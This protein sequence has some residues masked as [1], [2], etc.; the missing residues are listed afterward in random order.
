MVAGRTSPIASVSHQEGE[1]LSRYSSTLP[2]HHVYPVRVIP[3]RPDV[4]AVGVPPVYQH[5]GDA[6]CDL[7]AA[8]T[9]EIPPGGQV[10]VPTGLRLALPPGY[11]GLVL[12]RSGL[13][14]RHGVTLVNSPGLIDAGY[15]GEISV[16]MWNTRSDQSFTV[17]AGDRIAQLVIA[18][19]SQGLFHEVGSLPGSDRGMGGFGST[20][21]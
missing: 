17:T 14:L 6:G 18:P 2:S 7:L 1:S 11:M 3:D 21:V 5:P 13:A 4:L 19:F 9:L 20:G 12:P 8:T 15:R 16:I 10:L